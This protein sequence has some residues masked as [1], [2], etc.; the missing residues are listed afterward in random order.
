[1]LGGKTLV[2]RYPDMH[3]ALAESAGTRVLSWSRRPGRPKPCRSAESHS[4]PI[5]V[6]GVAQAERDEWQ[7]TQIV[8]YGTV[9]HTVSWLVPRNEFLPPAS[10]MFILRRCE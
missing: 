3:K 9:Y 1:M 2:D 7:P 8:S 10:L 5:R 6:G 4:G